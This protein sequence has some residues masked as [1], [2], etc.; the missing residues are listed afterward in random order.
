MSEDFDPR[1]GDWYRTRDGAA[2]EVVAVD[3]EDGTVEIQ[4][5][6]ATVEEVDL[7]TWS[8]LD[9]EPIEPPE[10]WSGPLDIEREDYG[11]DLGA[12]GHDE[13]ANPLDEF[14]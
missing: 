3:E 14:D 5:F 6:D 13:W 7:E 1:V 12:T 2:F 11:V 9:L 4:H 8:D 10:D